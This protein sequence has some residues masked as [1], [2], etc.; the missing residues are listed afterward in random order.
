MHA[1]ASAQDTNAA[2]KQRPNGREATR[3]E[4]TGARL[5]PAFRLRRYLIVTFFVA[6]PPLSDCT[7]TLAGA[8]GSVI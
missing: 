7:V 3:G 1:A 5:F 8:E 6:V 2:V 4:A